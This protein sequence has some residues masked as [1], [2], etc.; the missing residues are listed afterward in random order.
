[1]DRNIEFTPLVSNLSSRLE[2]MGQDDCEDF[3]SVIERQVFIYLVNNY[4][5]RS[6]T[7]DKWKDTELSKMKSGGNRQAKDFLNKQTDWQASLRVDQNQKII[8]LSR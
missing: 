6:V 3:C 8:F 7:M 1:M 2:I 5:V 4:F